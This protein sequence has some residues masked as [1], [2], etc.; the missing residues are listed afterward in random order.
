MYIKHAIDGFFAPVLLK[1]PISTRKMGKKYGH[2]MSELRQRVEPP[3]RL[4]RAII[5][6]KKQDVPAQVR[7]VRARHLR[8]R[9]SERERIAT[10]ALAVR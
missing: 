4:G 9:P 3:L 10:E 6:P 8:E 5:A 2:E 1:V 7:P